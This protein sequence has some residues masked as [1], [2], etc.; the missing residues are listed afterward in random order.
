[1]LRPGLGAVTATGTHMDRPPEFLKIRVHD[2][3]WEPSCTGLCA[4]YEQGQWRADQLAQHAMEWLPEFA[5]SS[6]E[7]EELGHSNAARFMRRA[8]KA[9]YDSKKFKKRGEFGELFLHIA[10]RQVFDSLPAISK[11]FYKS[12]AN[13]TVKGFDAVH[14]VGPE[15]DMELWLGEAK[16]YS[17]IGAAITSVVEEL[18]D[19]TETDYLRSEFLL[20]TNKID[21]GWP[22]AKQ[23]KRLIDPNTSLDEVFSR[24][25]I[26]V[27]LTYDS[28]T[29]TAHEACNT[30]Y[31][32]AFAEE[33]EEHWETFA[34]RDLPEQLHIHLFL[35]PLES[36]KD[37]VT[38][39]DDKLKA[40]Q[41]I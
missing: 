17:K 25:C 2:L 13:E 5:L 26:P 33:I 36:K 16:F 6:A 23:L 37:L 31:A 1:V 14:V 15:T 35:M 41:D 10:I 28:P 29:V 11:I 27:F 7:C 3:G 4:G 40:W 19:H 38:L 21:P 20:I 18:Q 30:D 34:G 32:T 24:V 39:L 12:A 8:A 22:H 9:V